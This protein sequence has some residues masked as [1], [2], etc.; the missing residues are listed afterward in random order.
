MIRTGKILA[1]TLILCALTALPVFAAGGQDGGSADKSYSLRM[2]LISAETHPVTV[3]S[4]SF[5]EKVKERTGGKIQIEVIPGGALGGEVE[6]QDMM[7][8]GVLDLASIGNA[9]P[10]TFNSEFQILQ[11]PFIWDSTEQMLAFANSDIQGSMNEKYRQAAGIKVL[12]SNWDQG[13]RNLVSKRPVQNVSDFKGLKIRVPQVPAW[14]DVWEMLGC[15][16]VVLAWPELYSALQQG[17]ADAAEPPLYWINAASLQE[18]AKHVTFTGHIMYYNHVMMNDKLFSSLPAEYQTILMEEAY[19][20][21]LMQS[22]MVQDSEAELKNKLSGDGVSFYDIDKK[23]VAEITR[24]VYKKWESSYGAELLE[25]VL[26]FKEK[27]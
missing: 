9:I 24:P 3:A 20:A 6:M 19:A 25:K 17:V 7:S 4:K 26:D 21:G 16:V 5:A 10:I 1:A 22:K 14:V 15:N 2:G 12:A 27:N 13:L 23:A 18:Q 11:M 8:E